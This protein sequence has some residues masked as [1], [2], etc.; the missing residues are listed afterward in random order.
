MP[1]QKNVTTTVIGLYRSGLTSIDRLENTSI[2][3]DDIVSEFIDKLKSRTNS[4]Q[5]TVF[6][7]PRGIGKTHL[8]SLIINK[9]N[10]SQPLSKRYTVIRFPEENHRILT[11]ADFL[12][13]VAEILG[14]VTDDQDWKDIFNRLQEENDDD[15]IIDTILPK[16]KAWNKSTKKTLLITIENLDALFTQQMKNIKSIH[17]LRSFLMD[18]PAA[19]FIGTSPVFFPGL[20][21][22]KHPLYD[23]FDVRVI[24]ELDEDQTLQLIKTNLEYDN[25]IERIEKFDQLIHKIKAIHVMTGGNPRLI[26]LLYGLIAHD[27]ILDVKLQFEKLLDSITP[28]YQDRIKDLPPQERAL[29]ETMALMRS[30]WEMRTPGNIARKMRKSARQIS[31]LLT[32]MVKSGY[33][34]VEQAPDGDKRSKV[35][36]IKEGFFD[37]WLAM[38]MSRVHRFSFLAEYFERWYSDKNE[39]EKKRTELWERIKANS[40]KITEQIQKET[41]ELLGYLSDIGSKDEQVQS[42]MEIALDKYRKGDNKYFSEVMNEIKPLVKGNI[43]FT[44]MTD[45]MEGW[46]S[47][48]KEE[49]DIYQRFETMIEY[50]RR[51]RSGDLEKAAQIA[52]NLGYD[53]SHAGLHRIN[54]TFMRDTLDQTQE[55]KQK[56][57]ILLNMANSQ[58]ISGNYD[59]AHSTLKKALTIS[60]KIDD[61]SR[62]GTTLNNTGQIYFIR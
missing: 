17:Q 26:L 20:N 39:R 7:G 61:K 5:H 51:Y 10:V 23:F 62:E 29:L 4:H 42:K 1:K 46:I 55:D 59:Q 49:E 18:N 9:V 24:S 16:I 19:L 54:I 60:R 32:R 3:R 11:F 31:S 40:G 15:I 48:E 47:G 37:L 35:Y 13:G 21:D 14:D 57:P 43:V 2:G 45:K 27:N 38:S 25:C 6:I 30:K 12:L 58:S 56:L 41:D 8:I 50:W 34:L 53:F 52:A 33:L 44:W 36:R 28:F 22:I